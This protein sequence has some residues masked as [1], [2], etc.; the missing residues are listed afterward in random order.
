MLLVE[1][2]EPTS[3]CPPVVVNVWFENKFKSPFMSVADGN[4]FIFI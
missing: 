2:L 1:P 3:V 4:D